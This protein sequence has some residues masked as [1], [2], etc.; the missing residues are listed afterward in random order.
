[1]LNSYT[2]LVLLGIFFHLISSLLTIQLPKH[3]LSF[4]PSTVPIWGVCVCVCEGSSRVLGPGQVG[5][6]ACVVSSERDTNSLVQ[7][8]HMGWGLG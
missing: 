4:C 7:T 5:D 3:V 2:F 8:S 6:A 1:M